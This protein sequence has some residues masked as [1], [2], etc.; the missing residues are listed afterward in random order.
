M[1]KS[2][3][4]TVTVIDARGYKLDATR[5]ARARL[6]LKKGRARILNTHPF[7]IQLLEETRGDGDT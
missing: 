3:E 4:Y 7:T 6:L 2:E 1:G 5:A